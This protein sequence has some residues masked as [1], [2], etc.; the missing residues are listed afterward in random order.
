MSSQGIII[1]EGVSKE[2][3]ER[4]ISR[5][6]SIP[7]QL[8]KEIV[9]AKKEFIES[10][11]KILKDVEEVLEDEDDKSIDGIILRYIRWSVKSQLPLNI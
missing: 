10:G 1:P 2:N 9:E 11:E 5:G 8:P 6:G 4:A 3:L 7:V